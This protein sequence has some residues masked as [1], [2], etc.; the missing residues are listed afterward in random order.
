MTKRAETG[1]HCTASALDL[2]LSALSVPVIVRVSD[3]LSM[4]KAGEPPTSSFCIVRLSY[5]QILAEGS[6]LES[7]GDGNGLRI[8]TSRSPS[9]DI[10]NGDDERNAVA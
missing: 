7:R 10:W 9:G 5:S 3:E 1:D 6:G 4:V 8:Q 2:V